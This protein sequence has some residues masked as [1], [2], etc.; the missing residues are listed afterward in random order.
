MTQTKHVHKFY[1]L[2]FGI[3]CS[4]GQQGQAPH[5]HKCNIANFIKDKTSFTSCN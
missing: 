5:F 4:E 1:F 2:P 3:C